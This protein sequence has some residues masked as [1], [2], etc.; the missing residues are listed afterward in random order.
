MVYNFYSED[1]TISKKELDKAFSDVVEF[2]NFIDDIT[3]LW[4]TEACGFTCKEAKKLISMGNKKKNE[5]R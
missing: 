5:T 1:I 3:Y 2:S 4:L